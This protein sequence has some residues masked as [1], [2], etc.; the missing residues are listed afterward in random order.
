MTDLSVCILRFL[1]KWNILQANGKDVK[2]PEE[3]QKVIEESEDISFKIRPTIP[4][5][6]DAEDSPARGDLV[7]GRRGMRV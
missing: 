5:S 6:P 3:L 2:N 1:Y 4:D 7:K